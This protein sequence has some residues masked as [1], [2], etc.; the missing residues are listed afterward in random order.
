MGIRGYMGRFGGLVGQGSLSPFSSAFTPE[1]QGPESGLPPAPPILV[2]NLSWQ[3]MKSGQLERLGSGC[4][5]FMSLVR[6][7]CNHNLL[8]WMKGTQGKNRCNWATW[9]PCPHSRTE[10]GDRLQECQP[11]W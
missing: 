7:E 9:S 10:P 2:Q 5:S 8:H 4:L 1:K 3:L 11:G 6:W